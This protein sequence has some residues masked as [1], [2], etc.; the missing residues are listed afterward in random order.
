M[1]GV[2]REIET[3]QEAKTMAM[4]ANLL[5][6]VTGF[7]GPL[8]IYLIKGNENRFVKFHA[9]QCL[10]F[11]LIGMILVL[12][13]CGLGAIVLIIF[14]IIVGLRANN[15]EWYEYPIVGKWVNV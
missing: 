4:L 5:A 14:N 2:G 13:T 7:I 1:D 9:L 3:N 12:V 11:E 6:I 8:V 15:G 10:Y